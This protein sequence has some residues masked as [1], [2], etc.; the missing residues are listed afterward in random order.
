MPGLK[1]GRHNLQKG[2]T[3]LTQRLELSFAK[4]I[5]L[6]WVRAEDQRIREMGE[7]TATD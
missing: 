7:A 6:I 1:T 2:T 3:C 5:R 4:T